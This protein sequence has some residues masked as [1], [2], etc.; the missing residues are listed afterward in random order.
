LATIL[1][2]FFMASHVGCDQGP[3]DDMKMIGNGVL[4]QNTTEIIAG[5]M[6]GVL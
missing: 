1:D 3:L 4:K 5:F 6:T 2:E